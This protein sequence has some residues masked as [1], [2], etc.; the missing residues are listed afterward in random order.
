MFCVS[1]PPPPLY[2][3]YKYIYIYRLAKINTGLS[4]SIIVYPSWVGTLGKP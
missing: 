4:D 2:T 1:T 3:Y